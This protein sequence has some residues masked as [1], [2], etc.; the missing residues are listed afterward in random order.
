MH[1]PERWCQTLLPEKY[2]NDDAAILSRVEGIV[3]NDCFVSMSVERLIR[4][5]DRMVQ[6]STFVCFLNST[7]FK[8]DASP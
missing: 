1:L 3:H 8:Y 2:Q 5:S 6:F 7:F 4:F